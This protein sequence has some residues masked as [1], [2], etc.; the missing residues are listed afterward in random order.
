MLVSG[1][2]KQSLD[3]FEQALI[4]FQ[5]YIYDPVA[6]LDRALDI[7]PDFTMAFVFKAYLNL[8][9]TEPE[10][11]DEARVCLQ[12]AVLC[13]ATEREKAHVKAVTLLVGGRW[14]E[15]GRVLEDISIEFPLDIL[16][17]QAGHLVDFYT[18]NS[19]MLRDRIAR[20]FPS[21]N[22]DLPGYHSILSMYAFGLEEF[23]EYDKAEALGREAVAINPRDGWG[24]HA[25]AHVLEMQGRTEE[26]INWMKHNSAAW[27]ADSFFQVHN[28]WHLALFHL[29]QENFTQVFSLYD[30]P[31]YGEKSAVVLDLIDASA[32]LWRLQ[33]LGVN[34]GN[35][36]SMLTEQ[37]QPITTKSG[38][39]FNDFHAALA[40]T[41]RGDSQGLEQLLEQQNHAILLQADNAHFIQ[42]VGRPLIM[43]LKSFALENYS[44]TVQ[45]FRDVRE[46][47]HRFGGSHAQRDII[48]LT[49]L[50]AAVRAGDKCLA[51]AL[52]N[53]RLAKKPESRANRSLRIRV[54]HC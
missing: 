30:G 46:I 1:A 21:W 47:A 39:A 35:R 54:G 2:N 43:G 28:W 32:L 8:L 22:S 51:T 3:I 49:L 36:W 17:L 24:Q 13:P 44:D 42:D 16:A 37:W 14:R 23:G 4:E 12:K 34:V 10:G 26:G 25:V 48:D 45:R 19:R 40:L 11:V 9:G 20:A 38:Y 15:A 41:A 6:T 29:D 7:T 27:S 18:G 5:S 50:E 52:L 53:E 33:L 31:I